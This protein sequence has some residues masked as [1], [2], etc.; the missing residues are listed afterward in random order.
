MPW[1]SEEMCVGCG[2][3]VEECPVDA[4]SMTDDV[5]NIHMDECI[6]CGT[7]HAV[8]PEE[9][10]RHDSEKVPEKIEE[11]LA[12]TRRLLEHFETPEEKRALLKRMKNHFN[13]ERKVATQTIEQVETILADL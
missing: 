13:N 6:H 12:W 8:C 1:V 9:A 2:I 5:A 10:V 3:C 11:N 7:C 4:I